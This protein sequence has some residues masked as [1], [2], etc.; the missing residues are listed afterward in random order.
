MA[1]LPHGEAPRVGVVDID[2]VSGDTGLKKN[3]LTLW[4]STAMAVTSTAPTYSMAST[5]FLI[6][7]AVGLVA[8]ATIVVSFIFVLGIAIA[9]SYFNRTNPNCGASYSWLTQAIS[10]FLGWFTGWIQLIASILFVITAPV[11][12]GSNTLTFLSSF[13][14]VP[15]SASSN[16]WA[17]ALVG[18]VWLVLVTAMV[19]YGIQITAHFQTAMLIIEYV[20]L[21]LF[22]VLAFAKVATV[23]P[24][25]SVPFSWQWFNPLGFHDV[26]QFAAGAVLAVFFYWGWDTAANVSEET[27]NSRVNPGRAGII[28]M[29]LL[30]VV[31]LISATAMQ[32][33]LPQKTIAT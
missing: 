11:L 21:L 5:M 15:A 29:V 28:G 23:H 32:S 2:I 3:A 12:A 4:D 6:A 20:A 19:V 1:T 30:L 8:P 7:G 33:L 17:V 27:S 22:S 13:G 26:G 31:F 18:L 24:K 9:Y 10:P 16:T 25:G 14:W